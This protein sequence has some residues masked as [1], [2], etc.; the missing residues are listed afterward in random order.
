M[1]LCVLLRLA[2]L[3]Y[4]GRTDE[5]VPDVVIKAGE[6]LIELHFPD[7]WLDQHPLTRADLGKECAYLEDANITLSFD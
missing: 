3:F 1:R 2:V 6:N 7:G 5:Q 4:R